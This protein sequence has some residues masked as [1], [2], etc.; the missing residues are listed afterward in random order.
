M[1]AMPA[2]FFN[3][4]EPLVLLNIALFIYMGNI[5]KQFG[6]IYLVLFFLAILTFAFEKG[7]VSGLLK[8]SGILQRMGKYA[9]SIYMTHTL[10]L[11]LFSFV[12]IDLL[13]LAPSAYTWLFTLNFLLVYEVSKW[14]YT[15]VEMRFAYKEEV[16]S[17]PVQS[18]PK[19]VIY[20]KGI[21]NRF[22]TS[23]DTTS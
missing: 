12:F 7:S 13:H 3:I 1:N 19:N 2:R 4:A 16:V 15:H 10:L 9:Y 8:Q 23:T 21:S 20:A 5:F 22:T 17:K 6:F 18:V 14:T 11:S